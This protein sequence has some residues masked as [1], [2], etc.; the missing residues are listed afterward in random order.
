MPHTEKRI[1][2]LIV[3][4]RETVGFA[5]QIGYATAGLVRKPH[6]EKPQRMDAYSPRQTEPKP[7]PAART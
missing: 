5:V 6:G 7:F 1:A 4:N 2:V 3:R